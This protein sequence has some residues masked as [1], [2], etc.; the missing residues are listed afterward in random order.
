MFFPIGDDNPRRKFPLMTAVLVTVNVAVYVLLQLPLDDDAGNAFVMKWGFDA[1]EPFSVQVLTSMFMHGGLMHLIGNMW[2]FAIVG[3]NVED[4]LGRVK[5]LA[6]YLLA[7]AVATWAYGFFCHLAGPV[8]EVQ[9]LYGRPWPPAVGASGAIYGVMGAYLVLFPWARIR[10][11][12]FWMVVQIPAIVF[13]GLM[14]AADVFSTLSTM[15]PA[16]GGVAKAAHAGGGVFGIVAMLLFKRSLGGAA[17]GDA[18]EVHTGYAKRLRAGADPYPLAPDG[19]SPH[20]P[21]A[22]GGPVWSAASGLDAGRG[23]AQSITDLVVQGRVREAIDVY[24]SYLQIGGDPPL[25]PDVQITIAHEYYRQGLPKLAIPAYLRYV[26]A[27]RNG[28]HVPDA[29]LRLGALYAQA[30]NDPDSAIPWYEDAAERHPD[31]KLRDYARAE[32]RRLGAG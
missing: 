13:M 27:D 29:A 14:I 5:Y 3:D 28:V 2:V 6:F 16:A 10:T 20:D 24:P 19:S 25:H 1:R 17:E 9:R 30:L 12:V 26:Q 32:L 22:P 7:G 11:V 23:I 15:G 21:A 31:P 4:K 18:W 8:A